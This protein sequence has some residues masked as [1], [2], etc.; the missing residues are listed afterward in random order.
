M[1]NRLKPHCISK[2]NPDS[3]SSPV[4]AFCIHFYFDVLFE[5]HFYHTLKRYMKPSPFFSDTQTDK[6]SVFQLWYNVVWS[7]GSFVDL[8][9]RLPLFDSRRGHIFGPRVIAVTNFKLK[10]S[11]NWINATAA[12]LCTFIR[13]SSGP[14]TSHALHPLTIT[15]TIDILLT[16]T[17]LEGS[18]FGLFTWSYHHGTIPTANTNF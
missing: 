14:N 11:L 4:F 17:S 16:S 18:Y 15:T 6:N 10:Q 8:L 13:Y 7:N 9:S 1:N 12:S 2:T 5:V 3:I